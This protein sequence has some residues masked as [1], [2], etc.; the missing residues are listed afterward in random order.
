VAIVFQD[1]IGYISEFIT[2]TSS[3]NEWSIT[4]DPISI[5]K[6]PPT[7]LPDAPVI[8]SIVE[9]EAE[10][11]KEESEVV[12][13][14]VAENQLVSE[15]LALSDDGVAKDQGPESSKQEIQNS[16]T[17]EE[18]STSSSTLLAVGCTLGAAALIILI[19]SSL[20]IERIISN[21]KRALAALSE[22]TSE[23]KTDSMKKEASDLGSVRRYCFSVSSRSTNVINSNIESRSSIPTILT[24]D[25]S[26][27]SEL[28]N[29]M[30]SGSFL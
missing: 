14:N 29:M 7:A 18:A 26:R 30:V 5:P 27:D 17:S 15:D 13:K 9:E 19:V 24:D 12:I 23:T 1:E 2:I 16:G 28:Y 6:D 4:K 20:Y 3:L 25:P 21:G 11:A 22:P 8:V 10:E